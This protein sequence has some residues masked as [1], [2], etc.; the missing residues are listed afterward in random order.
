MRYCRQELCSFQ[1]SGLFTTGS[2]KSVVY[3][4][5]TKESNERD[6]GCHWDLYRSMPIKESVTFSFLEK[7]NVKINFKDRKRFLVNRERKRPFLLNLTTITNQ[8]GSSISGLF[9]STSS[10]GHLCCLSIVSLTIKALIV[11]LITGF[12]TV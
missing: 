3:F 10:Y 6:F 7:T 4:N 1:I 8:N 12:T 2:Q 11:A 5:D 9:L